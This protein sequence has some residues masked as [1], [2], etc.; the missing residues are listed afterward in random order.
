[1]EAKRVPRCRASWRYDWVLD[2]DVKGYFDSIDWELGAGADGGRQRRAAN[3][4]DA[5]RWG[6]KPNL[7]EPVPALRLRHVDGA[8]LSPHPVRAVRGRRNLSLQ[9][10]RGGAGIMGALAD[11]FAVCKLVLHPEKTKIVY[12]KDANRR[13]DFPNQSF[14][15]LEFSF[16]AR[17]MVWQRTFPAHGF[18]PAV[19]PKALK[20]IS[21][22]IRRWTLRSAV[23]MCG[24]RAPA[25]C[26]AQGG[27]RRLRDHDRRQPG[28]S[29][30]EAIR[31]ARAAS[32]TSTSPGSR[33]RCRPTISTATSGLSQATTTP[34]A[35]GE[36][37]YSI[38][39]FREYMRKARARSCRSTSRASAASRPG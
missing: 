16:R 22:T 37:I 2:I 10:R 29:L 7:G 27:R 15:F 34:I 32:P 35:V 28:F 14:D 18:M 6:D 12:C 8:E 19:S 13:G 38:R 4:G 33:S 23:R 26:R 17:K 1:M 30:D 20:A 9:E 36:S 25:L 11:R 21:R 39:H 3:C 24:R 31:R 5:A